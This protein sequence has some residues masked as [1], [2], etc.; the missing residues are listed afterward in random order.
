MMGLIYEKAKKVNIWLGPATQD[1]AIG[2]EILSYLAT[3]TDAAS[4][5]P[6]EVLPLPLAKAG[7]YDIMS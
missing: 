1:S 5:P 2:I 3:N 7:L 4:K 6:W